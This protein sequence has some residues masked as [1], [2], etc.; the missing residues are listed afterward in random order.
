MSISQTL[1]NDLTTYADPVLRALEL[2]QSLT[3]IGGPGA[4]TALQV[5]GAVLHTL[6]TGVAA[7]LSAADILAELDKLAPAEAADDK[8]AADANAA[9]LAKYPAGGGV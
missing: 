7:Q 5:A 8:A 6:E 2:V 3:G 9:E 1:K 4:A